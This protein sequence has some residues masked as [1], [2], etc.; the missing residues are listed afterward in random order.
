MLRVPW[1]LQ[2]REM[3]SFYNTATIKAYQADKRGHTWLSYFT[4]DILVPGAL[5]GEM[6]IKN[7]LSN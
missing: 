7:V 1:M 4:L 3:N 2:H 6:R 5:Q